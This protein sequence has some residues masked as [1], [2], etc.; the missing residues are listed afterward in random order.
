MVL[1]SG[2]W[3]NGGLEEH[4]QVLYIKHVWDEEFMPGKFQKASTDHFDTLV[5][6]FP[7]IDGLLPSIVVN[8]DE[9]SEQ[10]LQLIQIVDIDHD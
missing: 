6:N 7:P 2:H 10:V 3:R 4:L 5:L 9:A 8:M 1:F